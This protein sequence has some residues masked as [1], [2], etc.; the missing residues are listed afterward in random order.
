[1]AVSLALHIAHHLHFTLRITCTAHRVSLAL[2]NIPHSAHARRPASGSAAERA[3][4]RPARSRSGAGV[5]VT[6]T[7]GA[8]PP[9]LS[10]DVG[11]LAGPRPLTHR[12]T[13][14]SNCPPAERTKCTGKAHLSSSLT[15]RGVTLYLFGR[16]RASPMIRKLVKSEDKYEFSRVLTVPCALFTLWVPPIDLESYTYAHSYNRDQNPEHSFRNS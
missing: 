6:R 13:R 12:S 4:T 14:P 2:H 8:P 10:G 11:R 3:L 7:L 1:M 15:V 16:A 9:P 5:K